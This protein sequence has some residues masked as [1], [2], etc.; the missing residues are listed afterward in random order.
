M[1]K[2]LYQEDLQRQIRERDEIRK[3]EN[4]GVPAR[5]AGSLAR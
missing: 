4:D 2:K 1:K 3:R 5:R